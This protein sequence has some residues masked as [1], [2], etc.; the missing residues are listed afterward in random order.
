MVVERESLEVGLA[1]YRAEGDEILWLT[2]HI[3]P[4][5]ISAYIKER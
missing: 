3:K 4:L 1:A 2:S 5:E